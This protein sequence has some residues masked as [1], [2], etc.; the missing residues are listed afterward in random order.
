MTVGSEDVLAFACTQADHPAV[1]TSAWSV[2][3]GDGGFRIDLDV[4][5]VGIDGSIATDSAFH[6]LDE[7]WD[8]FNSNTVARRDV[9]G[10]RHSSP[11][12]SRS[13]SPMAE[14]L[15][16]IRSHDS[17]AELDEVDANLIRDR[18]APQIDERLAIL[19]SICRFDIGS[20]QTSG[21]TPRG[22]GRRMSVPG[23]RRAATCG[24][25]RSNSASVPRR[26]NEGGSLP[27]PPDDTR[28][29]EP[30]MLP[31]SVDE[32]GGGRLWRTASLSSLDGGPPDLPSRGQ[33]DSGD[34]TPRFPSGAID[35][36]PSSATPFNFKRDQ[37]LIAKLHGLPSLLAPLSGTFEDDDS[38]SRV[39]IPSPPAPS[40]V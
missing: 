30:G 26:I 38:L 10:K 27:G 13:E 6:S 11:T 20:L 14:S 8:D 40:L 28:R 3:T 21:A 31:Y 37:A 9:I 17:R 24:Y 33:S 39:A 34:V 1:N 29:R 15:A 18:S 7:T 19:F 25:S 35:G 36:S 16:R 5:I 22:V 4:D 23:P 12:S 32:N 2:T